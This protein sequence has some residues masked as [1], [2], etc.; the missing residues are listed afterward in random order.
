[1]C[2]SCLIWGALV[3]RHVG[4]VW[5]C[6]EWRYEKATLELPLHWIT[7]PK[8]SRKPFPSIVLSIKHHLHVCLS[9]SSSLQPR[10]QLQVIFMMLPYLTKK[11]WVGRNRSFFRRA[12]LFVLTGAEWW[13]G[14]VTD[15]DL[16]SGM[17]HYIG[18]ID[19]NGTVYVCNM[20][21]CV[22]S[23]LHCLDKWK[24]TRPFL[25]PQ[26]IMVMGCS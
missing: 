1:M 24:Y 15:R 14:R 7:L 23:I 12:P 2:D 11:W 9:V 13:D 10:L 26:A 4:N 6:L 22:G 5:W 8:E 25:L 16:Q 20:S 17:R 19:V 18:T 21:S 3:I